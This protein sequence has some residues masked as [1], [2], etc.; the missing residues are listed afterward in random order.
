MKV[1]Y[2]AAHG[3]YASE[4]APL[5]GGAA[6]CDRLMEDW[7]RRRPF[8]L[9]LLSPA[10]VMGNRAPKGRDLARFSNREYAQFSRAFER[11]VTAEVLG[12]DPADTVVLANDIVE[13]PD[14]KALSLRGYRVFVIYHVDVI[15]YL[16]AIRFR[17][18]VSARGLVRLYDAVRWLPA[19]DMAR[20]VFDKQRASVECTSGVI[21]PSRGMKKTLLECYGCAP[22]TVHVLPWGCWEEA[23]GVDALAVRREF[24]VPDDALVLLTLSR[25]SP[26]KGQDALLEALIEWER[27]GDLPAR[28]L[29]LF[30]C[31][32]AAYMDGRRYAARLRRLA[33]RLRKVR[34]EFPGHV[35][36]GKKRAMFAMADVYVFPSR[37]ES[38]GLT[39]MEAL[40]EGLPAVCTDHDGAR[41]IMRPEF[42]ATVRSNAEMIGALRELLESDEKRKACGAAARQYAQ[43]QRFEHAAE[44][45]ARVLVSG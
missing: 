10:S 27:I 6:V 5:G 33:E 38:Y 7:Q 44:T 12:H 16:A 14:F 22:G 11:A 13:G 23:G 1:L 21:V 40:H 15:A 25:L 34:I 31:G 37:H 20:M 19:P 2:T 35:R 30:L 9:R 4:G 42:G 18:L 29:W 8:E 36:G 41:E 32:E 26:E 3:G 43:G 17:G 45:L 28:P 24:G 39:L